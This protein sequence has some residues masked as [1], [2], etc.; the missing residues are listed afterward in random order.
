MLVS[1][2]GLIILLVGCKN[3]KAVRIGFSNVSD[4]VL[5]GIVERVE[6]LGYEV[7]FEEVN[8]NAMKIKKIASKYDLLVLPESKNSEL[9]V[10]NA[11]KINENIQRNFDQKFFNGYSVPLLLNHYGICYSTE[12]RRKAKISYPATLEHF[13]RYLNKISSCS[14]IPLYVSGADDDTFLAFIGAFCEAYTGSEGYENFIKALENYES[15][16]NLISEK[17][18]DEYI[19]SDVL[20]TLKK[21]EE[22]GFLR[23]NWMNARFSDFKNLIVDNRIGC[24]F[25]SL[26]EYHSLPLSSAQNLVCD[27]VQVI[28]QKKAH[29]LV[30]SKIIC[31]S[32]GKNQNLQEILEGLCNEEGQTRL[33][34]STKLAP[35]SSIAQ[36]YDKQCD[37]VRFLAH[38]CLSGA[39][40]IPSNAAFTFS[41]EDQNKK[42]LVCS[43]LRDYLRT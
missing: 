6:Q 38:A 10:V 18:S 12:V 17:L 39:L 34:K 26:E 25:L 15:E 11:N 31:M 3:K 35:V 42:S 5:S 41:T 33:S 9:L 20:E 28:N 30:S 24:G 23:K 19:L 2:L 8:F 22:K 1:F 27:R 16:E 36:A 21:Y 29:G 32:F 40:E 13:E 37:D 43:V 4:L 14:D 7:S